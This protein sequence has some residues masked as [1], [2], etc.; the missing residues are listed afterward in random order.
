MSQNMA[1]ELAALQRLDF[2]E[3]R[4][5]FAELS[6]EE[7]GT[8]SNRV[9]LIKRIA[10]RLQALAEGGLSERARQRA[11]EIAKKEDLRLL[12]PRPG[13]GVS[14]VRPNPSGRVTKKSRPRPSPGTILTRKYKGQLVRVRVL[15]HGFDWEGNWYASLS[16]V[17][18]TVSGSHCSGN[19]FFRLARKGGQ[20]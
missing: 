5:K 7:L 8:I 15:T 13:R 3:L 6:G 11:I 17:A 1:K 14:V 18:K 12:P 20:K 2:Q 19:L 10:W 4:L 9:W 16:A